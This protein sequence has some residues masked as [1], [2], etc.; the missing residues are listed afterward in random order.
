MAGIELMIANLLM[1]SAEGLIFQ[2]LLLPASYMFTTNKIFTTL[3]CCFYFGS[4]FWVNFID[5]C[6][7]MLIKE[8]AM[9][10]FK[11]ATYYHDEFISDSFSYKVH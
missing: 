3:R 2:V 11:G 6:Y 7:K 4:N 5:W 8:G 10:G 9:N 1:G